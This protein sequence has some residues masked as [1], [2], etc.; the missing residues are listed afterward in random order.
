MPYPA[1]TL[2]RHF[3]PYKEVFEDTIARVAATRTAMELQTWAARPLIISPEPKGLFASLFDHLAAWKKG[4][5]NNAAISQS[6]YAR[7]QELYGHDMRAAMILIMSE[8]RL[9]LPLT[10]KDITDL[11]ACRDYE[12][13]GRT[14]YKDICTNGMHGLKNRSWLEILQP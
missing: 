14:I 9:E 13:D 11:L 10:D 5:E 3:Q 8:H 6:Y 4:P 7:K 1:Q 12:I 2:V